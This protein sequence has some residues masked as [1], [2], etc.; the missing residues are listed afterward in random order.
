MPIHTKGLKL[1][2][3]L[4]FYHASY[5]P[6]NNDTCCWTKTYNLAFNIDK[7]LLRKRFHKQFY[8]D[9][10][11]IS[12]YRY[13]NMLIKIFIIYYTQFLSI[14]TPNN[15]T[16]TASTWNMKFFLNRIRSAVASQREMEI[17]I[18]KEHCEEIVFISF[19][20][21]TVR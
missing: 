3:Y 7:Y 11:T 6:D 10:K 12:L 5:L 18:F 14:N 16:S 19:D 2:E 13:I 8:L 20:S 9:W 15:W 4:L 17:Y 21:S 1:C